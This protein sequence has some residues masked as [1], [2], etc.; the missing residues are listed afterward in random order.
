MKFGVV[1]FPGSNCEQDCHYMI[2]SV[3]GKP[4]EYIWHQDTSVKGFDAVVLPG[5][6][7]YGDYLRTGALARFSP[8]MKAIAEFSKKG[9]LVIG[10]CNGFQILTEAGLLPGALLRNIGLKFLCK[11]EYL[12][13]ETINTPFTNLLTKGRLPYKLRW[14]IETIR[15]E[16][17]NLIEFKASGDF[18]T[19]SSKWILRPEGKATL[20]TLDWNPKVEKPIV[21]L[22]SPVLKPVFEWNHHWAMNLGE[23]QL[24]EYLSRG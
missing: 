1:I 22:L 2:G 8:V 23:K 3:L 11:F 10:I 21:K 12:R 4:V 17:P 7:A 13:T 18:S 19:D 16:K 20:V 14:T 5:G 6:F 24:T 15:M 9:G